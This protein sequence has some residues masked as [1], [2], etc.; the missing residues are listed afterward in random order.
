MHAHSPLRTHARKLYP[1]EHL[2]RLGRQILEIDEVTTG[3]S[4]ST[5]TSPRLGANYCPE[6]IEPAGIGTQIIVFQ[7][8]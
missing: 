6:N 3:V 1:Y 4:L 2:R 7:E 5:G 8:K